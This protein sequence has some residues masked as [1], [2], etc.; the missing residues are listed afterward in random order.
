MAPRGL[1]VAGIISAALAL[2]A[3]YGSTEPASDVTYS[4]ATLNARGTA[5][6]GPAYSYFEYGPTG[7][8]AALRQTTQRSWPAGASG[9]FSQAVGPL[10]ASTPYS[11]RV[12]GGDEGQPAACAQTRTFTTPAPDGDAVK[13]SWIF[14][15]SPHSAN[16]TVDAR[17]GPSGQNPSGSLNYQIA[18]GDPARFIGYVTCLLVSGPRAAV[19]AVGVYDDQV[20]GRLPATSLVTILDAAPGQ[21][22]R[23][24]TTFE[25]GSTR[26]VCSSAADATGETFDD[27]LVVYDAP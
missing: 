11:F 10:Y 8:P 22:D 9:E 15:I 17:S 19:G 3:C 23:I 18:D 6:N 7:V 24:R 4:G 20:G 1:L 13:G 16:G 12:C 27:R 5:N 21:K 26:P 25:F 14:R 2:G